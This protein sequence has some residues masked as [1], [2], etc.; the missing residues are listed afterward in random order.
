[1]KPPITAAQA[2]SHSTVVETINT[3]GRMCDELR[4]QLEAPDCRTCRH[5]H[6]SQLKEGYR[7]HFAEQGGVCI[8]GNQYIGIPNVVLWRTE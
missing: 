2:M 8:N 5:V 1:M 3:L 4:A 7:C 6:W